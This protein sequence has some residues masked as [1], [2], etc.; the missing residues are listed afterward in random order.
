MLFC[1]SCFG[2]SFC[3]VFTFYVSRLS[4]VLFSGHI[5]VKTK[6]LI[7]L[8]NVFFVLCLYVIVVVSHF[9]FEGGNLVLICSSS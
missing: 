2:V 1:A 6:L 5:L 7:S 9:A 8:P 3:I 4:L